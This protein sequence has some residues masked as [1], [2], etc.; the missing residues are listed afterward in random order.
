[1]SALYILRSNAIRRRA[2]LVIARFCVVYGVAS[3]VVVCSGAPD[4]PGDPPRT[5]S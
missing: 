1:M 3:V 2:T 5:T 4:L